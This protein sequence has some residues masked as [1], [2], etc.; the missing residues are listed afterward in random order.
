MPEPGCRLTKRTP[1][2]IKI[3]KSLDRFRIAARHDY[4]LLALSQMNQDQRHIRNRFFYVGNIVDAAGGIEKMRTG[5]MRFAPLQ[6]QQAAQ[7]ADIRGGDLKLRMAE[8]KLVFEHAYGKI[9]A[10]GAENRIL[11]VLHGPKQFD[12]SFVAGVEPFDQ[13]GDAQQAIG[14]DHRGDHA[15]AA[16]KRHGHEF[17]SDPSQSHAQEFFQTKMRGDFLGHERAH[18]RMHRRG[19][20]EKFFQRRTQNFACDDDG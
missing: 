15:R 6:R 9:V 7:A 1:G 12:F 3:F 10:A 18:V 17:F 8:F 4:P 19:G 5:D 2:S 20:A 14:M 13:T 11:D 16:R